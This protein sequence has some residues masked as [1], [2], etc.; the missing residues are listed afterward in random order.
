[1]LTKILILKG[2]QN[3]YSGAFGLEL[4]IGES[5]C[6]REHWS[7]FALFYFLGLG[8]RNYPKSICEIFPISCLN[9]N[10]YSVYICDICFP[11]NVLKVVFF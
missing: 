11:K 8:Y 3:E 10:A 2:H 6:L 1:M 5:R 9:Y 4:P 7:F